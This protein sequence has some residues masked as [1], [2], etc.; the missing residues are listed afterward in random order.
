MEE[1]EREGAVMSIKAPKK[2]QCPICNCKPN[3]GFDV[4]MEHDPLEDDEHI[5]SVYHCPICNKDFVRCYEFYAWE[6]EDGDEIE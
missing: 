1:A 2:I 3:K 5:R 4:V 6:D